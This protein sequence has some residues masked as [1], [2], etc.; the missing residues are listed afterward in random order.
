MSNKGLAT[1]EDFRIAETGRLVPDLSGVSTTDLRTE[2]ARGLSLTA[3]TLTRLGMVWAELERRGEDLSDLRRGLARTLPLIAAGRLAAEAVVAFAG[4]P[5]VLRAIEGVPLEEQRSLAQGRPVVVI[6]PAEPKAVQEIPLDRLPSAA[7]R[8]VFADGEIRSPEAQ[9]LALRPRRR[10]QDCNERNWQPIYDP[11]S[12]T[13]RIGRMSVRLVDLLSAL[14]AAGGPDRPPASDCPDDYLT[15]KTRLT[16]EEHER[17]QALC[18][19][20]E[21][22]DWEMTRK[23]LR[24]FG[25]IGGA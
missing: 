13:V 14:A 1:L 18:R 21:L 22:P 5:S 24:A 6:D 8:L 3:E 15:V 25:L 23:A 11:A 9:R 7:L 12:G 19:R 2:L 17:F 20:F 10:S 4:R 16:R